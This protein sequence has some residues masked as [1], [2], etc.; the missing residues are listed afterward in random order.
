M[1]VVTHKGGETGGA[2][3]AAR[4]LASL[5][6]GQ[7]SMAAFVKPEVWQTWRCGSAFATTLMQLRAFRPCTSTT[8]IID[9]TD[10]HHNRRFVETR[11][12]IL[13]HT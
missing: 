11:G 3:G 1:P 8:D 7:K 4:A 9:S 6:A 12:A 2:L 13:L 10:F 5:M